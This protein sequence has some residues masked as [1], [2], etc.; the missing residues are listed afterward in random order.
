MDKALLEEL[1]Q[2]YGAEIFRYL[3]AMCRDRQT[4]SREGM[5]TGRN[6]ETIRQMEI[7]RKR[8]SG[9]KRTA[10]FRK[11][12]CLWMSGSGRSCS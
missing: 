3:Y 12:F 1:Y 6:P 11:R 10:C 4:T 2:R 5:H 7:L 9:K 8:R